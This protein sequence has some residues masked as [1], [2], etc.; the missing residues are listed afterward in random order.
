MKSKSIYS[1]IEEYV[2]QTKTKEYNP[3]NAV[4]NRRLLNCFLVLT[5]IG[6]VVLPYHMGGHTG[7]PFLACR[8]FTACQ[9]IVFIAVQIM[10]WWRKLKIKN[11][12]IIL[13]SFMFG[14][15]IFDALMCSFV[16]KCDKPEEII[17][18]SYVMCI[19]AI[20]FTIAGHLRKLS[21]IM[22]SIMFV[23]FIACV[24]VPDNKHL[25]NAYWYF[26]VIIV[27]IFILSLSNY[28][29]VGVERWLVAQIDNA[30]L[31][32]KKI[33][34]MMSTIPD[35]QTEQMQGLI[36]R[37]SDEQR[38]Q[39]MENVNN[40]MMHKTQLSQQIEARWPSLTFTEIEICVLII[41]GMALKEICANLGKS[42]TTVSS[43]RSHIRQKLGLDR[44]DH[45]QTFL[46]NNLR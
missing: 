2:F 26:G 18:G 6:I 1:A 7:R 17:I 45:L 34:E 5:L 20:I 41:K 38:K 46:Q 43:H 25:I 21:L 9:I 10:V 27:A 23:S 22:S 3:L 40:Y 11:A 4:I 13:L 15:Q 32:T 36:D 19:A 39:M 44:N 33:V 30:D 29:H 12:L 24:C 16:V 31:E 14:K 28:R 8:I 42:E 35:M 37:L